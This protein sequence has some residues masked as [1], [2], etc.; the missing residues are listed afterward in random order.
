MIDLEANT[1]DTYEY[2]YSHDKTLAQ[3]ISELQA[4][5]DDPDA[6]ISC[7][8]DEII[9]TYKRPLTEEERTSYLK[10]QKARDQFNKKRLE[11]DV[12]RFAQLYPKEAVDIVAEE[13]LK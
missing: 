10:Q 1:K 2:I 11:S 9:V 3:V 13:V 7:S 5:V 12:R 6:K 8:D 4:F